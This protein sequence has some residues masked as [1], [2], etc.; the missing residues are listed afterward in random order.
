ML[1]HLDLNI[2]CNDC[3]TGRYIEDE[4]ED[5]TKHTAETNCLYCPRGYEFV[6]KTKCQV[7][8]FSTYQ[9]QSDFADVKCKTCPENTFITDDRK[10]AEA[11]WEAGDC[12][13]CNEGKFAAAGDRFCDTC[14]AGRQRKDSSCED[15]SP[16]KFGESKKSCVGCPIGYYQDSPGAASCLPCIP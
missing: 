12:I 5:E 15:C 14:S 4:G 8:G 7:C 6:T 9:D 16:G 2:Q 11:H 3:P 1:P 10:I 13:A